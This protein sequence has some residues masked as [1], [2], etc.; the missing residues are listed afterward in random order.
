MRRYAHR[1]L[2]TLTDHPALVPLM[3]SR[4]ALTTRTM[5]MMEEGL[6]ALQAAGLPLPRGLQLIH[7]V[8]GLVIGHA[9][10]GGTSADDQKLLRLS[11]EDLAAFSQG[12]ENILGYTPEA[13]WEEA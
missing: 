10:A 12:L 2:A 5:T 1:L 11:E 3:L 6:G 13:G 9:I 4:A 8:T 7:A